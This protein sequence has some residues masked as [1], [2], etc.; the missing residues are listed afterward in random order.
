MLK[1]T[2]L[3]PLLA[4]L[5]LFAAAPAFAHATHA[6]MRQFSI[7]SLMLAANDRE[8]DGLSGPVRRVKTETAKITVKNGKP[9]EAARVLLETTTYDN[10]GGKVDNAYFLAAGG[11]LTGKE[12]YK[13]D[14][15]GNMVEMTLQNEDGS[16][17]S[18]EVYSYDFDAFGNW[19]KMTTS[20]AII[21]GG[22][23]SFEPSE[24]TYR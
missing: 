17:A 10:K 20:V 7:F 23:L 9:V 18:K 8:Q 24:V 14:A 2:Y 4:L 1:R 5:V 12:V 19:T 11:S 3:S 13:Y 22:K 16:L 21:E 15:K 6:R